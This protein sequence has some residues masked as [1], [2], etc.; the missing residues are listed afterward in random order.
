VRRED[1]CPPKIVWSPE[2]APFKIAAWHEK[3]KLPPITIDLPSLGDLKS[4]TPNVTFKVPGNLFNMLKQD[5]LAF[6]K[7]EAG[8]GADGIAWLCSFNIP[9]I[10]LVAFIVFNIF[11][12]LLNII[13]F[14]MFL[15]KICIPIPKS[16]M[17]RFEG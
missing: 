16:L 12:S 2:S 8:A 3:G 4:F 11:L 5:P 7:G 13:F 14:W 6:L 9:I 15:V 1:G 17:A 10:T